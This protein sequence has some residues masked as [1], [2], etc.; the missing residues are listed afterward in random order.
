MLFHTP[1]FLVFFLA[2]VLCF[3]AAGANRTGKKLVLFLASC[4][5]Y[6]WWSPIFILLLLGPMLVDFNVAR[7]LERTDD[8]RRR[9]WLL[10][11]SIFV[12]L[13]LL[14]FFKYFGFFAENARALAAAVGITVTPSSSPSCCP[15]ASRST[16]SRRSAT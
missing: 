8:S 14:G 10:S 1:T 12:N 2:V 9:G 3:A 7:W 11:A 4:V 16:R 6:M 15:W 5:F 13:G